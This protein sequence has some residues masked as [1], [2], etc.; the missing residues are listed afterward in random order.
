M[1]N[2]Q[3]GEPAANYDERK[4]R[5]IIEKI[6]TTQNFTNISNFGIW[7]PNIKEMAELLVID[8]WFSGEIEGVDEPED[9]D[10]DARAPWLKAALADK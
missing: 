1:T 3:D 8:M 6:E 5:T 2:H 10:G 7:N 4:I 9:F